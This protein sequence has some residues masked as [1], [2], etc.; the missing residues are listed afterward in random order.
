MA[1]GTLSLSPD[2]LN[3][4]LFRQ[5]RPAAAPLAKVAVRD[6]VVVEEIPEKVE[7]TT[8]QEAK[9]LACAAR[10]F[11]GDFGSIIDGLN[12][13]HGRSFDDV[14]SAFVQR[15]DALA[16]ALEVGDFES[17]RAAANRLSLVLGDM[18]AN[19]PAWNYVRGLQL[20]VRRCSRLDVS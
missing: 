13:I 9:I 4:W 19:I 17:A 11:E 18:Q 5:L 12:N 7:L 14:S 16:L 10:E 2:L 6:Q 15:L 3:S 20:L 8:E 1:T